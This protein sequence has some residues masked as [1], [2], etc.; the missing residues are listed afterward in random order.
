MLAHVIALGVWL[1]HAETSLGGVD[2]KG[3]KF[4][5]RAHDRF[6]GFELFCLR[7]GF[8]SFSGLAAGFARRMSWISPK[9]RK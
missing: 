4:A 5:S 1:A 9:A 7:H 6:P 3:A 8:T 2:S